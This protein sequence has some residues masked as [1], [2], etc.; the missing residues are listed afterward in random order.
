MVDFLSDG[1]WSDDDLDAEFPL[2]DGTADTDA[3]VYCPY[4][5]QPNEIALD[6]GSGAQQLYEEDCQV[7][8]QPWLVRVTYHGDGTASAEVEAAD[9]G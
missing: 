9:E 2:G 3:M 4:C 5:G 8:C 7:C 1:D 6:P